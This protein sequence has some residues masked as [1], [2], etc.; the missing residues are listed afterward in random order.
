MDNLFEAVVIGVAVIGLALSFTRFL[1]PFHAADQ[2]GHTGSSWFDHAEDRS[3]E[4]QADSSRNDPP[5]PRRR[6]RGHF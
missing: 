1:W 3:L 4:A 2:I 6:L 5:I